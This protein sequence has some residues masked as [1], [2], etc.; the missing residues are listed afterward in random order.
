MSR[1]EWEEWCSIN[2]HGASPPRGGLLSTG[3]EDGCLMPGAGPQCPHHRSSNTGTRGEDLQHHHNTSNQQHQ[4]QQQYQQQHPQQQ[5]Q[6]Q[7]QGGWQ[8]GGLP[9]LRAELHLLLVRSPGP[10]CAGCAVC[11][12][13][14]AGDTGTGAP[15][16]TDTARLE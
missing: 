13:T 3:E 14:G 4:Q 15:P 12:D 1:K 16:N 9:C 8:S 6:Q 7:W 11:G 10:R 2:A 5:Q